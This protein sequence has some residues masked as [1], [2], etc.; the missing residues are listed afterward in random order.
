MWR[1]GN[2]RRKNNQWTCNY[3][4]KIDNPMRRHRQWESFNTMI[5]NV[6]S[7]QDY[8]ICPR[9]CCD[10]SYYWLI[11]IYNLFVDVVTS[12]VDVS[13][14]IMNVLTLIDDR[15]FGSDKLI[16]I[17]CSYKCYNITLYSGHC[18]YVIHSLFSCESNY[19]LRYTCHT[20][21]Q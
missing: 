18:V 1:Q 6:L 15:V 12:V 7:N 21:V 10:W 19:Y 16:N 13:M 3:L 11:I 9:I 20:F 14:S 8:W 5:P 17:C 2:Y 4:L